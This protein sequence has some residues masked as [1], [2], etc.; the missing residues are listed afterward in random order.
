MIE[1]HIMGAGFA[2]LLI[3]QE[4]V[5][6]GYDEIHLYDDSHP[7]KASN[8]PL[9]LCHP[10]PGRSLTPHPLLFSAYTQTQR[11]MRRWTQWDPHFVQELPMVRP[12]SASGASRL[13]ASWQRVWENQPHPTLNISARADKTVTYS[14]CY[15][16][17]LGPLCSAWI[18]RLVD[19]G[20]HLHPTKVMDP[21]ATSGQRI[22]CTGHRLG[23]WFPN[24]KV[25]TEGGELGTFGTHKP[26]DTLISGGGHIAP[27][28]PTSIVAGAT[29][30]TEAPTDKQAAWPVLKNIADRLWPH[31]G[32]PLNLWQG[33][34]C[35]VKSDR[36]PLTGAVP[37]CPDT[38]VLGAFGSK[39]LLWGPYAAHCLAQLI[40][41]QTEVP[42]SL[43]TDRL[44][45]VQWYQGST[46]PD[47]KPE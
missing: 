17:R 15:S 26:L 44:P 18:Q 46:K 9:A 2:G 1:T 11:W 41:A 7:L 13:Y 14:P 35:I 40:I 24:L 37:N 28:T 19:S 6:A 16:V 36:L 39:G 5:D 42:L 22:F 31:V 23:T 20:V 32:P 38:Y 21:F 30:W 45:Q 47:L 4:L 29:R 25:H 12:S 8:A 43:S 10:F 34:R 33:A 3:A 27:E